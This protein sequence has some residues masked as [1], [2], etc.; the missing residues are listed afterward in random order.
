[1]NASLS[2]H[3]RCSTRLARDGLTRGRRARAAS[4]AVVA[5]LVTAITLM[6]PAAPANAVS[7]LSEIEVTRYGG[8]DRYATSL[9][10][11]EAFAGGAGGRLEQVVLVSGQQ[12]TDAVVAA[13]LAGA[14]EAP[15]LTTPSSELRS[16][17]AAF[18]RRTGVSDALIVGADSDTDGVGPSVVTELEALGIS[19]ERVARPDQYAT[20]VAAARRLGTPGD[21]RGH[22]RT[23]IVAS[24]RVFADALVA[25]P[26]AARGRHPILL[27]KP[28]IFRRDV[29]RYLTETDVEHVILMGGTSAMPEIIEESITDLGIEVTRLAGT[30]RYDTAVAAAELVVHRY[31]LMCFTERRAGLARGQVPFDAF[32]AA[33]LL[34]RLCTPLLLADP[35]SVPVPTARYLHQARTDV[36]SFTG[37]KLGVDVFGGNAAVSDTAID[38]YL[39]S[40]AAVSVQCDLDIGSEPRAIIDDVDAIL[41]VWSPDCSRIA[42]V[43]DSSIWTARIDGT[44][45][46]RLTDGS[47]PDWSPDGKRIAF[48][49][50]TDRVE[51]DR[52][53]GHIHVINIDGSGEAQLT[54][55]IASDVVPRWSPDGR[56]I[57]LRRTD[58][59]AAP[60][61]DDPFGNRYLVIIDAD[62]RNETDLDARAFFGRAHFWTQD[63]E[64][65]SVENP[66]SI[67]TVRDDGTDWKPVGPVTRSGIRFGEYAWSP[68][69]CRIALVNRVVHENDQDGSYA[70]ESYLKV[71][72]LENSDVITAVSFTGT[73]VFNVPEIRAPRWSP[74]GRFIAYSLDNNRGVGARPLVVARIRPA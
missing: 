45:R 11:A 31:G 23:A 69:G 72:N 63:G 27:T 65:I 29:A 55:A 35:D 18:L 22:G 37:D 21:M 57:L 67:A 9:R 25:G 51:H 62:G 64:R 40:D 46:V 30:T 52:Y 10:I 61:P 13:P 16:D 33:P 3:R 68:D 17:A 14:L 56:R 5:V 53:V 34:A 71:L 70:Y 8:A 59:S 7:N 36:G 32:S 50:R 47:S 2:R 26:F 41:P 42:Y 58:L 38:D 49:R 12:W 6:L 19:V 1:M 39:T 44:D 60:D 28:S 20:S 74:D 66:G 54:R 48:S 43:S 73:S 15:V 24:G 4:S